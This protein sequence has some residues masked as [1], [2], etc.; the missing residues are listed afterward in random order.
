MKKCRCVLCGKMIIAETQEDCVT[1]M[2]QCEAFQRVHP[3]DGDVNPN[4]VYPPQE[5]GHRE[6]HTDGN[7]T[8]KSGVIAEANVDEMSVKELRQLITKSGLSY[9][10]CIEKNDLRTRAKEAI[11]QLSEML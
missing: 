2:A 4:G 7:T 9:T 3:E 5:E 8:K 1:H 10:D 6:E 11:G